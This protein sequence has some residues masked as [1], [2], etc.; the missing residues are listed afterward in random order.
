MTLGLRAGPNSLR[1]RIVGAAVVAGLVLMSAF[2]VLLVLSSKM[3]DDL[4]R[5]TDAFIQEQDIADELLRA[6][7]RQLVAASF[8]GHLQDQSLMVDFRT[9]GDEVYD[10]IRRYLGQPMSAAQRLQLESVKE[11]HERME[12]AASEAA[13]RFR[14]GHEVEGHRFADAMIAHSRLL[15]REMDTFLAMREEDLLA[16]RERQTATFRYLYMAA[17]A[18][19]FLLVVGFIITAS[20]MNRRIRMPLKALM[21]A[22][23]RIAAGD[24][25]SRVQSR[26]NDEFAAVSE[27]FNRMTERL[28]DTNLEIEQRN[29]QLQ[30]AVDSLQTMQTELIQ[31]EKLSAMG[32]M[33]AGLAHELNNP[34]ASVLGYAELLDRH[35]SDPGHHETDDADLRVVLVQPLLEQAIRA[36]AL[37]RDFLQYSR[38]DDAGVSGVRLHDA[39]DVIVRL[40]AYVFKQAGL[41]IHIDEDAEACVSAKPQRLE[42]IFLNLTNNAFDAM[43]PRGHG[44]L[45]VSAQSDRGFVTVRF[46]DDGPG[47]E[48]PDRVFEPFFT[49]KPVGAGTGLGLTMVHQFMEEFGGSV[50]AENRR[51]GGARV[52]LRFRAAAADSPADAGTVTK[53]PPTD[54]IRDALVLVVEDEAPLR[55]LQ[56]RLLERLGATVTLATDA[57]EA[58]RL[59]DANVFDIIISDVRMP[60]T[61]TGVDLFRWIEETH[62][63][64]A[65]RFLLVTGDV[66]GDD[67]AEIAQYGADRI[68][69]KPFMIDDYIDRVSR[70]VA[71]GDD[72]GLKA[73]ADL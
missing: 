16:L 34:L 64:L 42:Q 70:M 31:T 54:V 30:S 1:R 28:A 37:V 6:V 21:N 24:L 18:L 67:I 68:L 60:G 65:D 7:S 27:S 23:T 32:R 22:T 56:K 10:G 57:H 3:R 58:Q 38:Q 26:H 55:L 71:L 9:A 48:F 41:G 40:R 39:L 29:A 45:R 62:P 20:F 11:Q 52:V 61:L 44:T 13:S 69:H 53:G 5:A 2:A 35:L 66:T 43:Q 49:T 33:M 19:A 4:G 12:V 14:H 8:F 50:R 25:Q 73:A 15:Q 47:F 51:E 36:R 17:A 63:H 72:A 59:V 46:E